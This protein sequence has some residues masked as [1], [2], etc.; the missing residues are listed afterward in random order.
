MNQDNK[1]IKALIQQGESLTLEF[2]S[3]AKCLPDCDLI[4]AVVSLANTNGGSLILGVEGSGEVTGLHRK[5]QSMQ[6][7]SAFIAN[8]TTPPVFVEVIGHQLDDCTIAQIIVQK[9]RQL[10]STS[11][12]LLQH[13]RFVVA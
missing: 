10:I 2:K 12:D 11:E 7:L 5:H 4:A 9:S 13:R 8:K 3:D 1:D 6:G